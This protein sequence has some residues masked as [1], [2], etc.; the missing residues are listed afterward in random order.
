MRSR[1][2][3]R[4]TMTKL[5]NRGIRDSKIAKIVLAVGV[6][7]PDSL[8]RSIGEPIVWQFYNLDRLLVQGCDKLRDYLKHNRNVT[9]SDRAICD[10]I[11]TEKNEPNTQRKGWKQNRSSKR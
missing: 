11:G 2:N 9:D 3:W 5:R 10:D 6:N 8:V 1:C 7:A 4:N